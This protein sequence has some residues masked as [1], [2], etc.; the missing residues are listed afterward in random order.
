MPDNPTNPFQFWQE[1]KRRKVV[2]V[3]IVYA[4]ASFVILDLV[5]I[6]SPSLRLPEWTMN[7]IIVLLCAGFIITVIFSWVYDI[8]PE[9]IE[10]TKP[11]NEAAK[12]VPEKS[13]QLKAWKIATIISVVIIVGLVIFH[14]VNKRKQAEDLKILDKSIAVLPF[15]N[16][17][18]DQ[19]RMYFINGTMEAILDNLCM[20]EDL[21]VPGRTSVE[22]YRDN[23][24]PIPTI[25]EELDVSYIL[26]GSGHRDGNNVRLIV[27]LLDGKKDQHLWSKT[28]DSD[29]EEIFSMQSE[30]A[31]LVAA[32]IEAF[33]TPEAK[34]LI[35]KVPTTNLTA[36]DFYQRGKDEHLRYQLDN[37]NR[38]ALEKTEDL[39]HKALEYDSA[40]AQAYTGLAQVYSEKHYWGTF[41]TENFL[42]S[43]MILAD[44]A[45]SFDDQLA[46]A[47]VIRGYY[48]ERHNQKAQAINEYD[49]AINLNPNYWQAYWQ[50]GGLYYHDDLVKVLDNFQ[51]VA[52]LHRGPL[53]PGIYRSIGFAYAMAGFKETSIYYGKEA[54]KLD[55]ESALYYSFLANIEDC[56]GNFDKAVEFG[57]KSYAIDSTD[58]WVI[59]LLGLDYLYLGQ[60]EESLEYLK[61]YDR[62]LKTLDRPDPFGI[63]RIGYA[64]WVN[65]FKEEAENYFDTGLKFHD[66]M[67]ELGRHYYK[68]LHTFYNLAAIYSFLGDKDKA[69]ENLRLVN[70]RQRMPLYMIANIKNDPLFDSIR[71]E[72]E[73]QQIVRDVEAKY[74]AEHERVRKWLE[75]NDML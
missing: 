23:P 48:Y 43:M 60:F 65:G 57:E 58:W 68:D 73:F 18:P 21:R 64:Y 28:Y 32:E 36:Y 66:E 26:E 61:K 50:K 29:I 46:E 33:I 56:N 72:P 8:T 17:S 53:L 24:K 39:Y 31:Q 74:Q 1:L 14:T 30:I 40:F 9:G 59:Y 70:Q 55:D 16:D 15:K 71:D 4:A 44:I 20:I 27:Q 10:K 34:Q 25:A 45:L 7:F 11:V 52:L 3:I 63:F 5:D 6:V 75:E 69:Y 54:H 38:E 42:D 19:E 2:R 51:K 35:Q 37:A 22:Q 41:L 12:E 62:R 47:Y 13:S 49:K 67:I